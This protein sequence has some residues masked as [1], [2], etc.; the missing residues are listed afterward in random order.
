MKKKLLSF[1]L[2][3]SMIASVITIM[4]TTV[5][6]AQEK[7][8]AAKYVHDFVMNNMGM[9]CAAACA[10][11]AN[12]EE[13]SGFNP[14]ATGDSGTS[15]GICQ[16]R[17]NNFTRLKTYCSNNGYDYTTLEAQMN[18]LN[19]D[20]ADQG[21]W[22]LNYLKTSE[23]T[24]DGAYNAAYYFCTTYEK[25]SDADSKGKVRGNLARDTYWTYYSN[26]SSSIVT[27]PTT[28]PST[29]VPVA[30]GSCGD[31]IKWYF[32]GNDT[33]II[34]GTGEIDDFMNDQGLSTNRGWD[35]YTNQIK[36]VYISEGITYIGAWTFMAK[37]SVEEIYVLEP[38]CMI[39]S[40]ANY[41]DCKIYHE[42]MF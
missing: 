36:K 40:G 15:Y 6:A 35:S 5:S 9:N 18:F 29:T 21:K 10:V 8:T 39:A 14:K 20:L 38:T 25:P 42:P 4:P 17:N 7:S 1:I 23:N 37:D 26:S 33:L 34:K 3:L 2:V 13:E 12:I 30:S 27:P 16:W 19:W 11:C 22:L 41:P 28:A 31:N 32:D 24:A